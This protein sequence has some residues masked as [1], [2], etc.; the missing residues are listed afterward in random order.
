VL[1]PTLRKAKALLECNHVSI[2]CLYRGRTRQPRKRRRYH[3]NY[4]RSDTNKPNTPVASGASR[5]ANE[6]LC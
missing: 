3:S 4:D 1:R 6:A 5:D 2:M